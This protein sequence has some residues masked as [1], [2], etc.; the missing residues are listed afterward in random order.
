M[1]NKNAQS[2]ITLFEEMKKAE[3]NRSE[4][5]NWIY[6]KCSNQADLAK[7]TRKSKNI[8]PISLNTFKKYCNI[9]K[10]IIIFLKDFF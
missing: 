10:K 3:L 4:S 2:V 5:Y 9:Y 6:L 7:I 8:V 1:L